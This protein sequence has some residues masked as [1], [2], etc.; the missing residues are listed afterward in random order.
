[1]KMEKAWSREDENIIGKRKFHFVTVMKNKFLKQ[2]LRL[3]KNKKKFL[4][5]AKQF[6]LTHC[7]FKIGTLEENPTVTVLLVNPQ[8]PR[9][10]KIFYFCPHILKYRIWFI[11]LLVWFYSVHI[12]FIFASKRN[13][14]SEWE[15]AFT[16]EHLCYPKY[17]NLFLPLIFL[18]H[19]LFNISKSLY[20]PP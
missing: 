2:N 18:R 10:K 4:S 13:N 5:L 11:P 16:E 12:S 3:W 15:E 19:A 6:S 8:K 1:M 20:W 14:T 17:L 9:N 7:G